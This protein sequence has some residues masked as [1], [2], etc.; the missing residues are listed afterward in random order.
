V[1]AS[2]VKS[3]TEIVAAAVAALSAEQ[4]Q[5]MRAVA[6]ALLDTTSAAE[7]PM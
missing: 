3:L 4:R 6:V 1:R 7:T 2:D 5:V